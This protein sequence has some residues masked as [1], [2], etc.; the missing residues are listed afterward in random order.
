MNKI[1]VLGGSGFIGRRLCEGLIS[2]GYQPVV[3]DRV[4]PTLP[5]VE[6][7]LG[8]MVSIGDL[9]RPLLEEV[10][11][12]FH[13]AWSTKPQSSNDAPYYDL[14]TNVLA[15][16]HFLDCMVQLDRPPRLIFVSSG[17]AIYGTPDYLPMDELHPTRPVNAYGIG[18]QTYER[19]LALY[20]RLHGLDYLVF[21]PGNPY[22]EGQDP[23]GAQGAVAV[24]LGRI[25]AGQ[26]ICIWGDG[27]IIRDYLYIGDLVDAFIK[28]I[29]YVPLQ[30]EERVFNVGSG[31]GLS[32][33]QLLSKLA[34]A[35]G[36]QPL[37]DYQPP[38]KADSSAVV[39]DTTLVMRCLEWRPE[40]S[41][42]DGLRLTWEW[43]LQRGQVQ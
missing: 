34:E 25:L 36:R 8:D 5:G 37:V 31:I 14:Q 3:F 20:R 35:T 32:L 40:T 18:K 24:F 33:T 19:Y 11:A 15:G 43:L 1:L 7:H 16:V 29:D 21:R 38:R 12:V 9:W 39:L 30:D 27:E 41:L 2:A 28:G 10:V 6:Y 23:A 22:G 13:L 26:P 17:G 42:E 4:P